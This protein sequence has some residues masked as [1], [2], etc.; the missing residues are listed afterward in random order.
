MAAAD[1][2]NLTTMVIAPAVNERFQDSPGA[3]LWD[4]DGTLAETERDGHRLAFNLALAE[5]GL[6]WQWS[7]EEYGTLLRISGGRER[8]S[9]DL[10]LRE[11]VIPDPARVEALQAS[12]QRHYATLLAQGA[13]QLR[14]GVRR[15]IEAA[16]EAGWSQAIVTTSG[17][18]A[19][20]ALVQHQLKDL[21]SAFTV[22]ICGEDVGRKKPDPEAYLRAIDALAIAPERMVAIEDSIPGLTAAHQAGLATLV[23]LSVYSA[24]DA[25]DHFTAAAAIWDGLG[26]PERPAQPR[27]GPA[28]KTQVDLAYIASLRPLS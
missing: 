6:P 10:T 26:D 24:A 23:T 16:R 17:R 3:L 9:H 14:P 27:R 21:A 25:L 1:L 4:V 20:E 12:K 19:V 2:P 7:V 18:Q 11:G 13:I 8:L 15:L 22:W 5:A 28:G